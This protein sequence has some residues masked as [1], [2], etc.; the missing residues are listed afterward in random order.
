VAAQIWTP[1]DRRELRTAEFES[2]A[3]FLDAS[4]AEALAELERGGQAL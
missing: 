2:A 1:A 4:M 3:R